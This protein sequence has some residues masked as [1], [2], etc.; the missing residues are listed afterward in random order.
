VRALILA[1]LLLLAAPVKAFQ[2]DGIIRMSPAQAVAWLDRD[3]PQRQAPAMRAR[4]AK[5]VRETDAV[6]AQAARRTGRSLVVMSGPGPQ[7]WSPSQAQAIEA[8]DALANDLARRKVTRFG[9]SIML[10]SDPQIRMVVIEGAPINLSAYNVQVAG[11]P[12][13]GDGALTSILLNGSCAEWRG[14][15]WRGHWT[16]VLDGGDCFFQA[17]YETSSKA[18]V[19]FEFNG[20]G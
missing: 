19:S 20:V 17:T 11:V 7:S 16:M 18:I 1:V 10:T 13:H 12:R 8:W 14:S 3:A 2:A 9:M 15:D 4:L 5:L 6:K